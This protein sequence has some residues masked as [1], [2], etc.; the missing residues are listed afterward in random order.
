MFKSTF[1]LTL[2]IY[3]IFYKIYNNLKHLRYGSHSK[4]YTYYIFKFIRCP[5]YSI[6]HTK[7]PNF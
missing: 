7:Q 6:I 5:S 2:R 4:H 1:Y 3:F